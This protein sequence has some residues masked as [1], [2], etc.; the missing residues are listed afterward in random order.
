M[1]TVRF[2]DHFQTEPSAHSDGPEAIWSAKYVG[3]WV[4]EERLDAVCAR[5]YGRT[6]ELAPT[7]L[8]EPT[9]CP[10]A[11]AGQRCDPDPPVEVVR[12][13]DL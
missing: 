3:P 8:Q 4:V 9:R 1:F 2:H 7:D 11:P 5:L 6:N 12:S 10:T 13:N